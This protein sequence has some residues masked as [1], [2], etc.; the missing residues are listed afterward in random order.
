VI[1]TPTENVKMA[2]E[3][4][5]Y[6]KTAASGNRR[7]QAFCGDCG[8]NLYAA[9]PELPKVMN[10]RLGC[11]NERARLAP[12]AQIWGNSAMPWLKTL[13]SVPHHEAGMTSP[14]I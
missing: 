9:E 12:T 10:L 13:Q 14:L 8:T 3:P 5:H 11:V 1:P 7:T 6:V 4:Q 2:G